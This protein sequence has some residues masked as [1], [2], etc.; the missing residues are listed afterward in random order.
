[1]L[2]IGRG[3]G[4]NLYRFG[5]IFGVILLTACAAILSGGP[6]LFPDS[7]G[8]FHAGH[9][10]LSHF[11][12]GVGPQHA[13]A[14]MPLAVEN[15]DG[16]STA[17]SV[18]YGLLYVL[19]FTLGGEW[20]LP[21]VQAAVCATAL[22]LCLRRVPSLRAWQRPVLIV[23]VSAVTGLAVFCAA[24]M[25]DVF[26]GLMLLAA[27]M[28]LTYSSSM[29]WI[30]YSFWLAIIFLGCIFH[31]GHLAVLAIML[32]ICALGIYRQRARQIFVLSA[33]AGIAFIA[34]FT[35]ELLV[36]D[37]SGEWPINTP[38]LLA[39]F[40][41]DGTAEPFLVKSCAVK[42]YEL[43][44]FIG[45]MPMSENEF[46][47]GTRVDK[48]VMGTSDKAVRQRIARE[49]PEIEL[50]VIETF[51]LQ[52][53]KVTARNV[54]EQFFDVGVRAYE[55]E[56]TIALDRPPTPLH[57]VLARRVSR[58]MDRAVAFLNLES[59][60]MLAVYLISV[61]GCLVLMRTRYG[62]LSGQPELQLVMA[63]LVGL[64][65]NALVF[66]AISGVFD[67]YQG[68]L[69]WLP[70]LGFVILL[71]SREVS[72]SPKAMSPARA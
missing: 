25:P 13:P 61:G 33:V 11:V 28:V 14:R 54:L 42:R 72:G 48:S 53:L 50:G 16:I 71:A 34:H 46:L 64:L 31:R 67:R 15:G 49:A 44:H 10:A 12:P 26:V 47:W 59:S 21:L 60:I 29:T 17:R 68:R 9:S 20:A 18:Y 36:K 27:A 22:A 63:M 43:C 24:A 1:V 37:M 8:Y 69:V 3:L 66:G 7:V 45:R 65:A 40:V 41:G 57:T 38:F 4:V 70:M 62:S 5:L 56:A 30:E 55:Q 39:R 52:E 58:G 6:I 51:P 32:A 23:L 2:L 35:V 19:A